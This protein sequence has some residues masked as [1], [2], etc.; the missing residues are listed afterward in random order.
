[1]GRGDDIREISSPNSRPCARKSANI[2]SHVRKNGLDR[3]F[4]GVLHPKMGSNW[5]KMAQGWRFTQVGEAP[6]QSVRREGRDLV[7]LTRS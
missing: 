2:F 7:N 1:M 3:A 6:P 5:L 4:L